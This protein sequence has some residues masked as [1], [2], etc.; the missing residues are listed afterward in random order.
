MNCFY[1]S[2]T[3]KN[4]F[5]FG[6]KQKMEIDLIRVTPLEVSD[7][8]LHLLWER[9]FVIISDVDCHAVIRKLLDSILNILPVLVR[10]SEI[11]VY[12]HGMFLL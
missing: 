10:W 11:Q 1:Y 4:A 9:G 8:R 3:K 6:G 12:L 7:H 5:Q 2:L